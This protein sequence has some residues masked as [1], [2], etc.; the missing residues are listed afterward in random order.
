MK[1][2]LEHKPKH[3]A[4]RDNLVVRFRD[5]LA[6]NPWLVA[7]VMLKDIIGIFIWAASALMILLDALF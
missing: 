7:V 5:F 6:S 3:M 2:K 1:T 4:K